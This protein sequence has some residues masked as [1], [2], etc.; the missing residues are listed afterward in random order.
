MKK[1]LLTASILVLC[2]VALVVGS[3]LTTM[4]LLTSSAS[5]SNVFTVGDVKISMYES[6]VN[7]DGQYELDASGEIQKVDTNSYHLVPGKTYIKDP[8]I[9]IN[10]GDQDD[11]YLFVK[12]NNMIRSAEAGNYSDKTDG[13]PKAMREQ[14]H[15]YGWVEY[16]RSG[17]GAEIVW[18]Y[19]TRDVATGKITPIPVNSAYKQARPGVDPVDVPAGQFRLCD[20]FTIYRHAQ[21]SLYGAASV[22]FTAFAIQSNGF[23]GDDNT[24]HALTKAAWEAVK[25]SFPYECGIVNPINPYSKEDGDKAYAAIENVAE[26]VFD[27]FAPPVAEPTTP[28]EPVTP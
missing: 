17:D 5:V 24:D 15:A 16:I 9:Y 19:G 22:T 6:K 3:V 14:M 2:A 4:A 10:S 12:S 13:T 20:E 27:L 8:T 21:V 11:M 23:T 18:V 7:S 28:S 26:P 1:K 25:G